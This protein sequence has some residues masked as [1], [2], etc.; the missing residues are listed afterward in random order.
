MLFSQRR[1][2][3]QLSLQQPLFPPWWSYQHF[4]API[5]AVVIVFF[6]VLSPCKWTCLLS[7]VDSVVG[8][9]SDASGQISS[10]QS[11]GLCSAAVCELPNVT[12]HICTGIISHSKGCFLKG[13]HAGEE[14][15]KLVCTIL[16]NYYFLF[17]LTVV[18]FFF[19]FSGP[20]SDLHS[21]VFLLSSLLP[22]SACNFCLFY[23][24]LKRF[25]HSNL[26]DV[27]LS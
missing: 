18:F 11:S 24:I 26:S 2:F 21:L 8:G 23:H 20:L 19:F 7:R 1:P 9:L 16:S 27:F 14:T 10:G 5:Y 3:P 22:P 15:H 25:H 4:L 12:G 13:W 6:S 17:V